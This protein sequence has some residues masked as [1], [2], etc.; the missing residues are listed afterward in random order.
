MGTR[1]AG[2]RV[3]G[4]MHPHRRTHASTPNART[5]H[6]HTFTRQCPTWLFSSARRH[7]PTI[8]PNDKERTVTHASTHLVVLLRQAAQ[9]N[10]LR[11]VRVNGA[12]VQRLGRHARG[13]PAW[14]AR[15]A[16]VFA[17]VC[18]CLVLCTSPRHASSCLPAPPISR[19][20]PCATAGMH[21][22]THTHTHTSPRAAPPHLCPA[23]RSPP[24][25]PPPGAAPQ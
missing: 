24:A 6:A 22:C 17:R 16:C 4:Q 25:P 19:P 10:E 23:C 21:Q 1:R 2:G 20:H 13:Q 15:C 12:V 7:R 14:G 9:A 8:G 5:V 18:T 11:D 3:R